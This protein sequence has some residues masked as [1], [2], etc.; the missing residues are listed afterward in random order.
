MVVQRAERRIDEDGK[1]Y[2]RTEIQSFYKHQYTASAVSAY[3]QS[4]PVAGEA[5]NA[6]P[7]ME[8]IRFDVEGTPC[9]WL[10]TEA[11]LDVAVAELASAT[12]IAV[13]VE[14]TNLGH[15]GRASTIQ[16]ATREACYV[17][18][19]KVLGMPQSLRDL[20][21][22]SE[23]LKFCHGFSGDQINLIEQFNVDFS[24]A[25]LFDTQVAAKALPEYTGKQGVVDI[26]DYFGQDVPSSVLD[27]MRSMKQQLEFVDFLQRPL[28]VHVVRYSCLDVIYLGGAGDAM[29]E[30]LPGGEVGVKG[31]LLGSIY[32]GHWAKGECFK[33][34]SERARE[35]K[36]K[37]GLFWSD[38]LRDFVR[39]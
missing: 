12:S 20:L 2:T 11:E 33:P 23:P 25:A 18:D 34:P 17:V 1:A 8:G 16:L 30:L 35:E 10:D 7:K 5:V 19:L 6:G 21:Q 29:K 4:L 24:R 39:Q 38:E 14:G 3:W 32:R 26:L 15:K 37:K 36:A 22:G 27:E 31:V 13:D 28:P 9:V